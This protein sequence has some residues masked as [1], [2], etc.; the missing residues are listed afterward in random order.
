MKLQQLR[1]LTEVARRGLNVSE[2]AEALHTSQPG[3]SKQIRALEDELGVQVFVRHGKRLVSVTEP[4]KA[5]V[6]DRRAH[7]RRGAEPA[8]RRRGVRQ[9]PA[10]HP[11]H[12]R[13]PYPGA[14][15][16]AQGGGR[17]QAALSEGRAHHPPG[18]PDA[19]LRPGARR[20]GRHGRRDRDDLA[21]FRAGFAA[22]VPVEPLRGGAAE[23]P[24][25]QGEPAHA[26]EARRAPDRHLR[27]RLRQP[28]AGAEGLRE[29]AA[30]SRTWC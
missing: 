22:G 11:D 8:P 20:R 15:R 14:L 24:A 13:H 7:P 12:R 5:V 19:D 16:P 2:A 6:A 29:R 30:S 28:L 27:L 26:G 9:R 17:L 23:A 4:G 1:C 25:A 10:R 3:V 21:L 18:Q